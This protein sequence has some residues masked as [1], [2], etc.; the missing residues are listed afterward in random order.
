MATN[1]ATVKLLNRLTELLDE[2]NAINKV[3][4]RHAGQ[5]KRQPS[6]WK[7]DEYQYDKKKKKYIRVY[8]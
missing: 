1:P 5:Q 2:I 3:L 8:H 7:N 6:S 4:K